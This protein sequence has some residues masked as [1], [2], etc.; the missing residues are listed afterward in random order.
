MINPNTIEATVAVPTSRMVGQILSAITPQT[1][2][3]RRKNDC[4]KFSVAVSFR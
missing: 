2:A 1:S 3:P 4:P